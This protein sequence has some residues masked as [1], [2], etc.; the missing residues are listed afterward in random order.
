MPSYVL[1]PDTASRYVRLASMRV[2]WRHT[3][4]TRMEWR[5]DRRGVWRSLPV[6]TCIYLLSD[7]EQFINRAVTLALRVAISSFSRLTPGP[8]SLRRCD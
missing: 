8:I 5:L 3:L 2:E 6:P 1:E 4:E 7:V